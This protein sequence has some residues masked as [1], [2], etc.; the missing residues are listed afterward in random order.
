M[1]MG[2][3]IADPNTCVRGCCSSKSIPLHLQSSAFT[4]LSPIA[5]GA[6]STVYEGR[7]DGKKVAV[8]KPILSTSEDLDKFHKE[9]Q[10]LCELDHPSI[11]KLVAANAKPPSYM[12][13][14]E[15]YESPNLAEKL[16]AEEWNPSINQVLMITLELAKALQYL[17]NLGIVHRDVKPANVL[18]DK[19]LHPYLADFGLAVHRKYLKGISAENWKSSGK[20][21]GGF[22]KKSMVGT[23]IYMAPEILKK[24]IHSEL[25]D[26]YS[27]GILINELLTGVVPYTD[28][29]TEAQAHTVLEMNYT[30]Q[31]LTAAIVSGGLRPALPGLESG[32][33]SRFLSLI[34]R[35]W[36]ANPKNRP[37]FSDIVMDLESI[38][39]DNKG[40]E[41]V[42]PVHPD[43]CGRLCDTNKNGYAYREDINWSNQGEHFSRQASDAN[44]CAVNV[45]P[46]SSTADLAYHP[47]LSCGSFSTC[48]RRE[49]M[50][51]SHF[52]LPHM[53][54]EEDI[55]VFGI[56][57]GHRGA[58]AAE[59]SA[60]AI[61]GFLRNSCSTSS[62]ADALVET[63]VKTDIE[64]R[65]ELDFF[66]QSKKVKQKDWHP[67][68]TAVVALIVRDRL[69]VANAGDCRTILCRAGNPIVLS[70]DHVASCLEE[71]ERVISAGGQV[72]WLVD[73]WRVGPA[74]LQL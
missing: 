25:S 6:E 63:F 52:L 42:T 4:L 66:R 55:H 44:R 10:L 69:F 18:L 62:P 19:D 24:E 20:P 49:T 26:V 60:R 3:Q 16:H 30:E 29:R 59:F 54:N 13:F 17:H 58:A 43:L 68:C 28:L 8:K 71:R 48:G 51:D 41:S 40:L 9:L 70:K 72:T 35:C 39:E 27:F 47:I 22:Y 38:W 73:T 67:G 5:R 36:D 37:S 53:C 74:A 23:L 65:K 21:T 50:E 15:F 64:F 33:P 1:D 7:L 12:F 61:P 2:L 57:D 46:D 32:T 14:F 31:L 34:R 56:F 11:V 45:W